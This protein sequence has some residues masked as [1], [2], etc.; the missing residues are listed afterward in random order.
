[1]SITDKERLTYILNKLDFN[2]K[3]IHKLESE[4]VD[5]RTQLLKL[6]ILNGEG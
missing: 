1:M 3:L 2:Q 4:I 5:L 6:E